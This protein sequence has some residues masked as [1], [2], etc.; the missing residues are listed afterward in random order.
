QGGGNATDAFKFVRNTAT[1]DVGFAVSRRCFG[2]ASRR[3]RRASFAGMRF[4]QHEHQC[5]TLVLLAS[6]W[7]PEGHKNGSVCKTVAGASKPEVFLAGVEIPKPLPQ[8]GGFRSP[9][10]K[11]TRQQ[12]AV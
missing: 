2:Y 5:P 9:F 11:T 4:R 7:K 1:T 3:T 10:R 8:A 6:R 12:Q